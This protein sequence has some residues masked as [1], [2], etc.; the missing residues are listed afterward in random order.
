MCGLATPH[1]DAS[2]ALKKL[3]LLAMKVDLAEI[4]IALR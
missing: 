3:D 4:R 1:L 2:L